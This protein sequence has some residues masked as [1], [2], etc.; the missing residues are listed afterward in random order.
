MTSW[1]DEH[2]EG[3]EERYGMDT[4]TEDQLSVEDTVVNITLG[5]EHNDPFAYAPGL[6]LHPPIMSK[7]EQ[8]RGQ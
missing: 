6:E 1:Q 5:K 4:A 2:M 3:A 7:L 8:H